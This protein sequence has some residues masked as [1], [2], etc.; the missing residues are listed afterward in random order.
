MF[1]YFRD[2]YINHAFGA[3]YIF[4]EVFF[5]VVIGIVFSDIK[6]LNKKTI[7][8]TSIDA[9]CVWL[10]AVFLE[11]ILYCIAENTDVI[12]WRYVRFYFWPIICLIHVIVPYNKNKLSFR[13]VYAVLLSAFIN[14][15]LSISGPLGAIVRETFGTSNNIISDVT[16]FSI[17]ILSGI[18]LV[19]LKFLS[20]DNYKYIKNL[21]VFILI[22]VYSISYALLVVISVNADEAD[23]LY[24]I[25][26][27]FVLAVDL[28][29]YLMFHLSVRDNENAKTQ[30]AK[31]L[32]LESELSQVDL[33][34]EKLDEM[35]QIRHE[36]K[37]LFSLMNVLIQ[38][39]KY[40]EME[41]MFADIYETTAVTLNYADTGNKVVN[42]ILNVELTKAMKSNV[43][44]VYKVAVPNELGLPKE[45]LYS[46]CL[47]VLDNAIESLVREKME[48]PISFELRKEENFLFITCE[49]PIDI[50]REPAKDR[51]KLHTAKKER[52]KHGYGTKIIAQKVQALKGA[53]KYSAEGDK[54]NVDIM[55]PLQEEVKE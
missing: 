9:V 46:I 25:E 45:D 16:F 37:N 10:A 23:I 43:K 13:L 4:T 41:K 52:N 42:A 34:E 3:T 53:L 28:L 29:V 14:S 22:V 19:Y 21:H 15:M 20:L 24:P 27:I 40:D 35:H 30:E 6:K 36:L 50:K 51:L 2:L 17:L 38:E 55:I 5:C 8:F 18:I 12:T 33:L 48:G 54:F 11:S 47:N 1:D 32:L 44:I 7:L 39:K 26:I 31:N 49:N